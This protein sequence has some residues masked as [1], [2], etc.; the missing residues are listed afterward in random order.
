MGES[1]DV[2]RF[3]IDQD[4]LSEAVT[5]Y[6]FF[7]GNKASFAKINTDKRCKVFPFANFTSSLENSWII[8]KWWSEEEKLNLG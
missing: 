6:S 1:R 7:K 4:D 8:D 5:L 3:D 2:Y